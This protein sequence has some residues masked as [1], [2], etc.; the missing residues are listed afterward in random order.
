MSQKFLDAFFLSN[1][2]TYF[3]NRCYIMV[4]KGLYYLYINYEALG[5]NN[6]MLM[7]TFSGTA[8][9]LGSKEGQK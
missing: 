1:A 4:T 5:V 9:K 7:V 6:G 3:Q 2:R 8:V